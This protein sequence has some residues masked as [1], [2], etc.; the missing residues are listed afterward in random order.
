MT[1]N[2][3]NLLDYVTTPGNWKAIVFRFSHIQLGACFSAFCA[4]AHDSVVGF[5]FLSE[6]RRAAV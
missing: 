1:A 4:R 5:N 3:I 6:P 2:V